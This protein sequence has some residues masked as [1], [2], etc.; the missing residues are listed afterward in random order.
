MVNVSI[1]CMCM[2]FYAQ[3][4]THTG[5]GLI[6]QFPTPGPKGWLSSTIRTSLTWTALHVDSGHCS[7]LKL[8]KEKINLRVVTSTPRVFVRQLLAQHVSLTTDAY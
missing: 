7:N 6:G 5:V 8:Y 1:G 3:G 2:R 4:S